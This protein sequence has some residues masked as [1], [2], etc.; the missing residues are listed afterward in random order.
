MP[1]YN[2]LILI[3]HLTKDVETNYTTNGT[4]VAKSTIAVNHMLFGNIAQSQSDYEFY[5]MDESGLAYK[6]DI[7][8][9]WV[10]REFTATWLYRQQWRLIKNG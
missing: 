2:K 1:N 7:N 8:L 10:R 5:T 3:G 6:L 4:A 9:G